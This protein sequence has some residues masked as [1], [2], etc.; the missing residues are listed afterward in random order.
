MISA[1]R[2][3]VF[4]GIKSYQTK[5]YLAVTFQIGIRKCRYWHKTR[6]SV[7]RLFSISITVISSIF[8]KL[9]FYRKAY[10]R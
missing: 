9:H 7:M 5:S 10:I 6:L 8:I 3:K 4:S 1:P 2:N